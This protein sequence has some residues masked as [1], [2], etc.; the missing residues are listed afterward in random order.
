MR[1]VQKLIACAIPLVIVT[2]LATPA[3]AN[4]TP[5]PNP[6]PTSLVTCEQ[7]FASEAL[8]ALQLFQGQVRLAPDLRNT[9]QTSLVQNLRDARSNFN[10]CVAVVL[11]AGG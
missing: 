9:A 8:T 2:S 7:K 1:A 3:F 10:G 4:D 5:P 11:A 6:G